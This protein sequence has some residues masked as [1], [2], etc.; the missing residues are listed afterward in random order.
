[1]KAIQSLV[2]AVWRHWGRSQA[3]QCPARESSPKTIDPQANSLLL[4]QPL[5]ILLEIA[6]RLPPEAA[7]ALSLTC[8]AALPVFLPRDSTDPDLRAIRLSL[9][10]EVSD[11]CFYCFN[12]GKYHRYA[13]NWRFETSVL[14]AQMPTCNPQRYNIGGW[15]FAFHHFQLVMNEHFYGPGRGLRRPIFVPKW[16][17]GG[18]IWRIKPPKLAI[19]NG[20]CFLSVRYG[21]RVVGTPEHNRAELRQCTK[22][23]QFCRHFDQNPWSPRRTGTMYPRRLPEIQALW[24]A[25]DR[26]RIHGSTAL[27]A[28]VRSASRITPLK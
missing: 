1:M 8:E 11:R 4:N 3:E 5:D 22:L 20:Q 6:S 13:K 14:D 19:L 7:A 28:R 23:L 26:G 18:D 17:S 12:C 27:R 9:E 10:K 25:W 2:A 24:D 21:A 16:E 15:I